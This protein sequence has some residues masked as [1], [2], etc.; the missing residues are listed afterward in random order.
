MR[1]LPTTLT[2]IAALGLADSAKAATVTRVI[3]GDTI[4]LK[5]GRKVD[6]LGVTIPDCYATQARAKL[7]A[8]LPARAKVRLR[9]DPG[10]GARYVFRGKTLVN[11]ELIRAGAAQAA[12][13]GLEQAAKLTAAETAAKSAARGLWKTCAPPAPQPP[14]P[15]DD[16]KQRA[17]A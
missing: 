1:A 4:A 9:S 7:R 3:D 16:P 11:A 8:L 15:A 6:L 14:P 13:A 5:D 17:L 12:P 10:H 2:V